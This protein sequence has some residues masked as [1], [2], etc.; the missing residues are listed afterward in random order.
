MSRAAPEAGKKEKFKS[1]FF[2][3]L[4]LHLL[5]LLEKEKQKSRHGKNNKK[6]REVDRRGGKK[7]VEVKTTKFAA[8]LAKKTNENS[9]QGVS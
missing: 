2:P 1:F 8:L 4:R 9:K 5:P 7:E 6:G 3:T